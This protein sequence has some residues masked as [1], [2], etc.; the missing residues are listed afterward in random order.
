MT[1]GCLC[2][3]A[4][5]GEVFLRGAVTQVEGDTVHVRY[6]PP[7]Q[8]LIVAELQMLNRLQRRLEHHHMQFSRCDLG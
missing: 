4:N 1:L 3:I 8:V 5:P 2:K 6:L 7:K